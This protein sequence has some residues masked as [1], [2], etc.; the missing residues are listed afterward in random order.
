[1][2]ARKAIFVVNRNRAEAIEAEANIKSHLTG[3]EF[4]EDGE[5]QTGKVIVEVGPDGELSVDYA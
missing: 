4:V 5:H 3:F 2:S 1:M